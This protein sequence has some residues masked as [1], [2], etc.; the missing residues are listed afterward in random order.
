MTRYFVTAWCERPFFAQCKVEAESAQAALAKARET[1]LGAPAEECDDTYPWDEWRVDTAE[2]DG[3][4]LHRDLP[5]KLRDTAPSLLQACRMVIEH[6]EHG[7]L[8]EAARACADAVT[9]AVDEAPPRRRVPIVI[10]VRGGIVEHVRNLPPGYDYEIEDFDALSTNESGDSD[11]LMSEPSNCDRARWAGNALAAFTAET[12]SGDHPDTMARSDL[13]CAIGDLIC[14]LLHLA[15]EKG[16]DS[17]D[18]LEHGNANFRTESLLDA[19]CPESPVR[20][21]TPS[22]DSNAKTR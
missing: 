17:Q 6:W 3:V 19:D 22:F 7:D 20:G 8:A 12:F 18:V 10:G 9:E 4:L 5:A 13:E 16:F 11:T 21:R 1:I 14:D 15:C 2:A